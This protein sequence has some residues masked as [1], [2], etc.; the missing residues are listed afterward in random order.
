MTEAFRFLR[1]LNR[2]HRVL[3]TFPVYVTRVF[4]NVSSILSYCKY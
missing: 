1:K 2:Y 3:C 4:W